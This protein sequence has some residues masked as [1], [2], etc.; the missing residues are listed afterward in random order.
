MYWLWQMGP[1]LTELSYEHDRYGVEIEAAHGYQVKA[2]LRNAQADSH[3]Q[4]LKKELG[5]TVGSHELEVLYQ[6]PPTLPSPTIECGFS[7]D[8]LS[9]L[10]YGRR[11]FREI[12]AAAKRG[13]SNNGIS[14]W[15]RFADSGLDSLKNCPLT[16]TRA[17]DFGHGQAIRFTA[18]G[19][20]FTL[21]IGT[22]QREREEDGTPS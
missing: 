6:I 3:A 20:I 4:D 7:P 11:A 18:P 8:Y 10:R 1:A 14:T 2:R 15:I 5:L 13:Y 12:N 16:K 17:R 21:Y 22:R 9:I 19:N